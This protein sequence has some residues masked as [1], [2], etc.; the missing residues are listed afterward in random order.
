MAKLGEGRIVKYKSMYE[1][2]GAFHIA[3]LVHI[4][5]ADTTSISFLH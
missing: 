3:K 1:A 4:S 2:E 5:C